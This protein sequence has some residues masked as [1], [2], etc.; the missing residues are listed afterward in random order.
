MMTFKSYRIHLDEQKALEASQ[1]TPKASKVVKPTKK[2]Q[3]PSSPLKSA[4][5]GA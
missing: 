3:H 5:R 1:S 2:T 4:S